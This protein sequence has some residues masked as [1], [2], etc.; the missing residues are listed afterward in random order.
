M[1]TPFGSQANP[2]APKRKL[3][4][5]YRITQ[6]LCGI[7]ILGA[8]SGSNPDPFEDREINQFDYVTQLLVEH[9]AKEYRS[10]IYTP[11]GRALPSGNHRGLVIMRSARF[12]EPLGEDFYDDGLGNMLYINEI[13][14]GEDAIPLSVTLFRGGGVQ[15]ALDLNADGIGDAVLDRRFDGHLAFL[16]DP[17]LERMLDC[18]GDAER[19]GS[20][21]IRAMEECLSGMAG[22]GAG[23][24]GIGSTSEKLD[25]LLEPDCGDSGRNGR[26]TGFV[27]QGGK[28]DFGRTTI[29]ETEDEGTVYLTERWSEGG[30]SEWTT[31]AYDNEGRLVYEERVV[32]DAEGN[33]VY[34]RSRSYRYNDD[35][36]VTTRTRVRRNDRDESDIELTFGRAEMESGEE[37]SSDTDDS[38]STGQPGPECTIESD[39]PAYDPRCAPADT[40]VEH[41]WD[42]MDK[43]DY[44]MVE[45]LKR[46]ND[47]LYA[48]TGGQCETILGPDDEPTM[49]CQDNSLGACVAAGGSLEECA[50]EHS[51]GYDGT[52]PSGEGDEFVLGSRPRPAAGTVSVLEVTPLGSVF[53]ALCREGAER[54]CQDVPGGGAPEF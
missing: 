40:E 2:P 3:I 49:S 50:R 15:L 43:T 36:T 32:R 42:C 21:L 19:T 13:G 29:F 25:S 47:S 45:C 23:S 28:W 37:E 20:D 54:F 33:E 18:F 46:I 5:P 17:D 48:A 52:D 51:S 16:A 14:T 27:S 38:G 44:S 53:L 9:G 11:D 1:T 22:G 10:E 4:P 24:P 41:L 31:H 7:L 35:G 39:C 12:L 30:K 26:R 8:C 34:R 6:S